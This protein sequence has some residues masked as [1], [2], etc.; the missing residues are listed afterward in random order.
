MMRPAPAVC[1]QKMVKIDVR[2]LRWRLPSPRFRR[3][4][5][6]VSSTALVREK[7][8]AAGEGDGSTALVRE[9]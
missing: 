1:D 3:T 8:T 4:L 2:S 7:V 5:M 9:R 6:R